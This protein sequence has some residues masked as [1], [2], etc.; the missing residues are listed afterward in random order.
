MKYEELI[1]DEGWQL[2]ADRRLPS[3][4]D[5]QVSIPKRV[6]LWNRTFWKTKCGK[7][8]AINDAQHATTPWH[9]VLRFKTDAL[10]QVG[11]P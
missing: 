11:P 9:A 6:L 5:G 2:P 3:I 7:P 1:P 10:W 4:A 8:L